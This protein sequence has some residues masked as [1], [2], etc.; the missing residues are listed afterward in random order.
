MDM[1]EHTE[2][3]E[4]LHLTVVSESRKNYTSFQ[5]KRKTLT[6]NT[7]LISKLKKLLIEEPVK[8][9]LPSQD[10]LGFN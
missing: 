10:R 7:S 2:P 1:S 9:D 4:S 8:K 3:H 6:E 5:K